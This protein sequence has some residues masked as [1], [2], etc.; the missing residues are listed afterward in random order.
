MMIAGSTFANA[1]VFFSHLPVDDD[2][3]GMTLTEAWTLYRLL[4]R[5]RDD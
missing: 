4:S 1:L 2:I 3:A 5:L